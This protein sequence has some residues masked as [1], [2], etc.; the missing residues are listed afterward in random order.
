M[1]SSWPNF[2]PALLVSALAVPA[3]CGQSAGRA[4]P[5][6]AAGAAGGSRTPPRASLSQHLWVSVPG[7]GPC[8]LAHA[9]N[10]GRRQD[11]GQR[12]ELEVGLEA[13]E[14]DESSQNEGDAQA[15]SEGL[16]GVAAAA[17]FS[18]RLC[19]LRVSE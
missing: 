7:V 15:R 1:C 6:G 8:T 17:S 12:P 11:T 14:E 16:H 4:E 13:E 3:G 18:L 10:R 5:S 19:S 2:P 9:G